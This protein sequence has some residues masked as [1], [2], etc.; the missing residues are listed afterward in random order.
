MTG[1]IFTEQH[2]IPECHRDPAHVP[3]S[4]A[5]WREMRSWHSQCV[6]SSWAKIQGASARLRLSSKSA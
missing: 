6:D 1:S 2:A 4:I 3:C 5:T